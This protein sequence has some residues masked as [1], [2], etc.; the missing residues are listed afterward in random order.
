M[1]VVQIQAEENLAKAQSI[2]DL[3]NRMKIRF[4]ELTHS[5]Y[6]IH[7]LDWVFERPI[8]KSSD[9][10][11]SAM[12]PTPTAKRMLSVLKVEGILRELQPGSGRRAATIAYPDLLNIAE[13]YDAF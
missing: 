8:F 4:A 3:Y 5:Q 13:G 9:F 7:A 10:V 1:K 11:R 12:I 2:L 6:A